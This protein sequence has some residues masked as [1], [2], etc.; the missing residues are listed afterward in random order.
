M[1]AIFVPISAGYELIVRRRDR[2]T[3]QFSEKIVKITENGYPNPNYSNVPVE[4]VTELR[5]AIQSVRNSNTNQKNK[6]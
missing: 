4:L 5:I 6:S 3:K 2:K 1:S